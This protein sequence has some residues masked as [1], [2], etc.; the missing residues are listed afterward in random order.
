MFRSLYLSF[1][2]AKRIVGGH[3]H[4]QFI[5]VMAYSRRS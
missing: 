5:A 4:L 2:A 1:S 3:L